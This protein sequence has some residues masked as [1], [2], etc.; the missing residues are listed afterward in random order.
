MVRTGFDDRPT[1]EDKSMSVSNVLTR[2]TFTCQAKP[3][4]ACATQLLPAGR[5]ANI[6]A[7]KGGG[8]RDKVIC[9]KTTA[10]HRRCAPIIP[11]YSSGGANVAVRV[12]LGVGRTAHDRFIRFG[13]VTAC[14]QHRASHT[15]HATGV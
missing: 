4:V 1:R 14:A 6:G 12:L 5:L 3:T 11:L 8:T 15:D 13:T 9:H 2:R 10:S 7:F